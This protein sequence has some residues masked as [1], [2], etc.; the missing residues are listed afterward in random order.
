MINTPLGIFF[1][2][3]F[4]RNVRVSTLHGVIVVVV[5]NLCNDRLNP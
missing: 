2:L 5:M 1:N 3:Y 4:V